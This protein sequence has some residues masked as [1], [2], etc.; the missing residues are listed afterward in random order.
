MNTAEFLQI[1]SMVAPD[2]TAILFEGRRFSYAD[3]NSRA[4]KLA[5]ALRSLGIKKGD[6]VG[7]MQVNCN[8][9]V[10][11]YFACAKLGAMFV[12]ISYRARDNEIKVIAEISSAK[13]M[14]AGLRYVPMIQGLK[15]SLKRVEHYISIEGDT[16]GFQEYEQLISSFPDDDVLEDVSDED[17]TILMFTAGTTGTPKGVM[18]TYKSVSSFALNNVTP[19][20]PEQTEKNILT[21]PLYHIAG[22]QAAITGVYGGRTM[23][24][25]RQFEAKAWMETVQAERCQRAMMVPTMLKQLMDHPDFKKHDL[26][27]LEVITYGAAPMP[28]EVIKRAI[29]EFPNTRFINAF[30]QTE[31]AATITALQPDD[32]DMRGLTGEAREKKMKR[33]SS[34][35]RPLAGIEIRIVDEDGNEVPSGVPGEIV[36]RGEQ[37]M[38]G[39][40]GQ[41][42][43]TKRTIRN[44]WLF[45]GDLGYRD[46][47]GYIFLSGRAKDLIIRGGENIAPNEIEEVILK[48]PAVDDCA[49]IGLPD[50]DWGERVMAV[51]VKKKGAKVSE[52]EI[53]DFARPHLASHKRP[54]AVVFTDELPRN[55]MGKVLKRDLREKYAPN[56]AGLP[57]S[58]QGASNSSAKK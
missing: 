2:K 7:A 6:P 50:V 46:E 22:L 53:I 11:L 32:H 43:E 45:T 14:F 23:V 58:N 42:A 29:D 26:S 34:I 51:V 49:V 10:E 3:L 27:S 41:E 52:Q 13:V 28:L 18:L 17:V 9:I 15:G 37:V 4:N 25:Q 31:S 20:D 30:G 40:Y 19:L 39:Y 8:E 55:V 54:E 36:A 12:P 47:E 35:G 56:T 5:H 57:L 48:H 16:T 33:L 21:V 1:T 44:G 38:K 24:I